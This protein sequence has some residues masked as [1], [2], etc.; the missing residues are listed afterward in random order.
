MNPKN[1]E[2]PEKPK[3]KVKTRRPKEVPKEH[4]DTLNE[5]QKLQSIATYKALYQHAVKHGGK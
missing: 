1:I 2:T 3:K 5:A 4:W